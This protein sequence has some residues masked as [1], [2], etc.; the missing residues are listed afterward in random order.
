M[1]VVAATRNKGRV[2]PLCMQQIIDGVCHAVRALVVECARE[3]RDHVYRCGCQ[4]S[5]G[6]STA[7]NPCPQPPN[8]HLG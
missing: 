3:K 4:L 2:G 6:V 7:V 5:L 1:A 8:T